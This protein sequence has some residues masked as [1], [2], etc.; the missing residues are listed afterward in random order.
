MSMRYRG[1]PPVP[2]PTP[3]GP[4]GAPFPPRA[5][6]SFTDRVMARVAE[7][8]T[9]SPGRVFVRSLRRLAVRDAFTA[10]AT[11]WRLATEPAAPV[12]ASARASAAALFLS[13]VV[14]IGLGGAFVTSGVLG[15]LGPDGLPPAP[16]ATPAVTVAPTASP[17]PTP[18]PTPTPTPAPTLTPDVTPAVVE[19]ALTEERFAPETSEPKERQEETTEKRETPEPTERAQKKEKRETPEPK[20]R[21]E[22][23]EK[24]ERESESD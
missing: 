13:V 23:D 12:A 1:Q 21:D 20:E 17:T 8:P 9:P 7:E 22:R 24:D 14:L 18:A 2:G 3:P 6:G 11:A 15:V 5:G 4:S 16:A 19:P 10:L